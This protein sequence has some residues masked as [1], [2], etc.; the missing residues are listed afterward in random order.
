MKDIARLGIAVDS[1]R[2]KTATEALGKFTRASR[3]AD[4]ASEKLGET[5]NRT[6]DEFGRFVKK[7]DGASDANNRVAKSA[8]MAGKALAGISAAV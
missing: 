3:D 5:T 7:A 6:R 2:V 4:G 8:R 1:G